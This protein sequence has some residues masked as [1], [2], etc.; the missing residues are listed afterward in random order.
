M[1]PPVPSGVAL[2]PYQGQIP[3][4]CARGVGP[5]AAIPQSPPR[6]TS[7]GVSPAMARSWT[8]SRSPTL[9]GF[10]SCGQ[11]RELSIYRLAFNG[12]HLSLPPSPSHLDDT[13]RRKDGERVRR[14]VRSVR[15]NPDA[16]EVRELCRR[17]RFA[18]AIPLQISKVTP[19][20]A[21]TE[22]I[23]SV[24]WER[25]LVGL[26]LTCLTDSGGVR[27]LDREHLPRRSL[28]HEPR[29]PS[30]AHSSTSIL[31]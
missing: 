20:D 9:F 6:I 30:H 24:H 26:G 28:V 14:R 16:T 7:T 25:G 12:L 22:G 18:V 3:C 11:V 27:G 19:T 31:S 10:A 21:D 29:F 15:H 4:P 5:L 2:F 23:R 17:D 8:I 1:R 13:V